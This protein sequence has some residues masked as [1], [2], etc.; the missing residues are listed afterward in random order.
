[1]LELARPE[2]TMPEAEADWLR[3]VYP[4]AEVILEYGSGGS[5]LLAASHPGVHVFAVESD[6]A[7]AEN[8]QHWFEMNPPAGEVHILPVD[9]GPT[10]RWGMPKDTDAMERW[11]DYPL[12]VWD[13][14]E[15][16]HPDIVLVDGRFRTACFLATLFRIRQPVALY[17]DNYLDRSEYHMVEDFAP[18]AETRGRMARFDLK[19]QAIPPEHLNTIITEFTKRR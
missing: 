2:F 5:T 18:I 4:S 8:M 10:R 19:P 16:R 17:F 3:E 9:V 1:M 7:W 14:P 13:L 15:F 12:A 6:T 11:P